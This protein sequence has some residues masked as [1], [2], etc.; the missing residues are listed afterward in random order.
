MVV[1]LF[2]AEVLM[3]EAAGVC[4]IFQFAADLGAAQLGK[5]RTERRTLQS[6]IAGQPGAI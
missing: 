4:G 3:C 5:G 1:N 6:K 2:C